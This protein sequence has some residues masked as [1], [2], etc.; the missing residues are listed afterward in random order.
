MS[1]TQ[2]TILPGGRATRYRAARTAPSASTWSPYTAKARAKCADCLVE[3][4]RDPHKPA[5]R[6]AQRRLRGPKGVDLLVCYQHAADRG[7]AVRPRKR[8]G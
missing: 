5:A 1:G 4:G 3:L 8:A 6:L 7:D 2:L